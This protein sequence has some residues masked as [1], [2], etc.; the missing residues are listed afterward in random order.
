M[1]TRTAWGELCEN[2]KH[3]LDAENVE[4]LELLRFE[5][6]AAPGETEDIKLNNVRLVR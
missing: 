5:G 4:N 1:K 3:A 2:Y 6:S